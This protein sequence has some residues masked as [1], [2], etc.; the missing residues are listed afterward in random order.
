MEQT[1]S[2]CHQPGSITFH[3]SFEATCSKTRTLVGPLAG[4]ADEYGEAARQLAQRAASSAKIDTDTAVAGGRTK[5]AAAMRVLVVEDDAII[6]TLLADMRAA[7]GHDVFGIEATEAD[8]VRA[9]AR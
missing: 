4:Y 3:E 1:H 8:A 9:A 7:M 2:S 5:T 6:G